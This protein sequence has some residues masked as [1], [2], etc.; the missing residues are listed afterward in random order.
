MGSADVNNPIKDS[1]AAAWAT[2]SVSAH[3]EQ[4]HQSMTKSHQHQ[5]AA[6]SIVGGTADATE[7]TSQ[8][9]TVGI[10]KQE[11]APIVAAAI[12]AKDFTADNAMLLL[13]QEL[14]V[15]KAQNRRHEEYARYTNI[16]EH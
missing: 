2:P 15:A 7:S 13:A 12:K 1:I 3:S 6:Q 11:S 5:N 16:C 9:D 10:E 8:P 4:L 14:E